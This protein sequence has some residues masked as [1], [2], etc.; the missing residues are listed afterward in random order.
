MKRLAQSTR[1]LT[2]CLSGLFPAFAQQT[3]QTIRHH[4]EAVV[5]PAQAQVEQ[6]E[7][8]IEKKDYPAAEKFLQEATS[9]DPKNFR[10]WYDLGF[11]YNATDRP[12]EAIEAYRKS[13]E[14]NPQVFESNLN[15][16]LLLERKGDPQAAKY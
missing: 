9:K 15:L 10:A 6:A 13:V 8:A 11:L 3:G 16:G 5:D 12:S 4:H 7:S 2:L 1:I 14:A